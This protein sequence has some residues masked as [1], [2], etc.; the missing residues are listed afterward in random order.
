M[1]FT[2]EALQYLVNL[3]KAEIIEIDGQKYS[4]K[5]IHHIKYPSPAA[6]EITTLSGLVDYIKSGVDALNNNDL[7]IHV[8]DPTTV[9]LF[10]AL[11]DDESRDCY[12]VVNAQLPNVRFGAFVPVEPFNIMIQSAFVPNN[13][14]GN[15]LKVVGNITEESIRNTGDDGISQTVTA[16]TGIVKVDN[17]TVPNPVVLRPYRTFIEVKQPESKF[18]FRMQNGPQAA[19]F[20]ADGGAW[21]TVAMKNIKEYLEK[22]LDGTGIKIIS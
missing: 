20:E 4:A 10:S 19:L 14:T 11:W 6:I 5:M 13:D 1:N 2:K 16:K 17:V 21:K 15:I 22:E 9:K 18:V 12:V 7:L 8:V 3:D